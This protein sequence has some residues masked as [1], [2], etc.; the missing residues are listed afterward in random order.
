M[1]NLTIFAKEDLD[2]DCV[3]INDNDSYSWFQ[4]YIYGGL[5]DS[6]YIV[7][8]YRKKKKLDRNTLIYIIL[9]VLI[10]AP[11]PYGYVLKNAP[12]KN[13]LSYSTLVVELSL[14]ALTAK[15]LYDVAINKFKYFKKKTIKN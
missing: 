9:L 8:L 4:L 2:E 13:K 5:Y 1:L 10:F 11:L 14:L 12:G 6:P 15:M 7:F 3:T